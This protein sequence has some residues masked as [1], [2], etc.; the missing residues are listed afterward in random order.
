M[1]RNMDRVVFKRLENPLGLCQ[2]ARVE[3]KGGLKLKAYMK[4]PKPSHWWINFHL[5]KTKWK[6]I[7]RNVEIQREVGMHMT[8]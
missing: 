2:G 1:K 4:L 3:E 8:Y 5:L 7:I 6:S